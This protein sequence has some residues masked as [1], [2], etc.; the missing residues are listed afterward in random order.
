MAT[1]VNDWQ[2]IGSSGTVL[3]AANSDDGGGTAVTS[4]S[5]SAFQIHTVVLVLFALGVVPTD[6]P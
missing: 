1:F 6:H 4:V 2:D 3:T 5:A